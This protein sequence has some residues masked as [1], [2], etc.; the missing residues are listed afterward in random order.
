MSRSPKN[1]SGLNQ[2]KQQVIREATGMHI[3]HLKDV[4]I[5]VAKHL[6]I[7]L[8]KTGNRDIQARDAGKIGGFIGG[9]MVKE[10]V[11]MAE[12]ELARDH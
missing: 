11:R 8:N 1:R 7:P 6:N 12:N 9:H 5:E 10:M 2:F 4:S 3:G